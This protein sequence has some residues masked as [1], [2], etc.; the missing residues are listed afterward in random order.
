M[1]VYTSVLQLRAYNLI[2]IYFQFKT[3]EV[4][5]VMIFKSIIITMMILMTLILISA[6]WF[7]LVQRWE[8]QRFHRHRTH[9]GS[10][11]LHLQYGV[12]LVIHSY[13]QINLIVYH[14][15]E[16]SQTL[17]SKNYWQN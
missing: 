13:I 16:L 6:G 15:C 5:V 10:S 11:P 17:K 2:D 14:L 8:G 4:S 1:F 7:D 9:P 12:V 3:S